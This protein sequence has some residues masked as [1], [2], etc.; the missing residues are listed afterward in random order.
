VAKFGEEKCGAILQ[1]V[2]RLI[3]A[4]HIW[5]IDECVFLPSLNV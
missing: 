3:E 1:E 4:K 5:K 2:A